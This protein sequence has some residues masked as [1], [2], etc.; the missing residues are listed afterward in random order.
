MGNCLLIGN[1]L[2]LCCKGMSWKVLLENIANRYFMS[3]DMVNSNVLA[4]EQL[5]CA[6]MSRNINVSSE[7]FAFEI[8]EKLDTLDYQ[9]VIS[10]YKP[11]LD[12]PIKNILTT[13]FD[14]SIE[15][16]LKKDYE[17]SKYTKNVVMPQETKCS[18]IRHTVID[19]KNIFHIHGELGK[20]STICMGNIHYAT[21]L[22]SIMNSIL[23]YDKKTDDYIIKESVFSDDNEFLSWAQL[24]FTDDVYVVGL[25]LYECDIDLWW[26]ISYRKQLK[27]EGKKIDNKIVYYYLFEEKDQNFID[28]LRTMGVEVRERKI[29]DRKWKDTYIEIAYD[30]KNLV[31]V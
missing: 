29:V 28:C 20:K 9:S 11:F 12:L 16:T 31:E 21:N 3:S 17:Y 24:F 2:N 6:V 4:F 18:R 19:G 25:G 10:I 5:K 13:N 14:Y 1:G 27:Q 23:D 30:I 7:N 26:L 22:T 15:K 8:L